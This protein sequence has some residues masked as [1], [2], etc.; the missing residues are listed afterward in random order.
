MEN[1]EI[2]HLLVTT[3]S[4]DKTAWLSDIVATFK[5]Y[6]FNGNY[7]LVRNQL[8]S[9]IDQGV[10][11]RTKDV[12]NEDYQHIP[13]LIEREQYDGILEQDGWET[14]ELTIRHNHDSRIAAAI[15][16]RLENQQ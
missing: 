16:K 12:Y 3:I 1:L 9:L 8:Q 6:G 15:I 14:A 5:R 7:M 2:R 4:A 10:V 11:A 13:K